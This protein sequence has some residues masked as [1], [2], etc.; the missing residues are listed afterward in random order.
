MRIGLTYDLRD[1]YLAE[2]WPL[3]QA[4]EFD[5]ADTVDA[6]EAAIRAAG[7]TTE[8]IGHARALMARL[9]RGERWGLVFNFAEGTHGY[10]RESLVPALLD[11][12]EIPYTF[13]DPLV[14][15][16]TLHKATAK[17]ILRDHGVPTPDFALVER[18]QDAAGVD[19]PFPLFAKPV[20]E[21]S[22]KGVTTRS[23]ANNR[24]DLLAVCRDLIERYNQPALVETYLPGR[25]FTVGVLG[26][27]P[28]ARAV[29]ALE[30]VLREG[31]DPGDYTLTNKEEC[32]SLVT[33]HVEPGPIGREACDLALRAWRALGCRDGGR[34]DVRAD[35]AGRLQ[36]IELNPLPGLHPQ[37]SDL[38]IMCGLVGVSH[39][40]LIAAVLGSA[41][42][43]LRTPEPAPCAS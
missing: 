39:D 5:R 34:V 35:A 42:E 23:R 1:D 24:A 18:A 36:V 6:I 13:S 40:A 21:G 20:A 38:P 2:G 31:A 14:C 27:G 29:G 25:E 37:H 11:A 32:E 8:R 28:R 3:D 26:T 4:A 12:F 10:G 43:R 17:R 15:A 30:V 7:H 33:Y 19:L 22:S 9:L 16:V 41:M